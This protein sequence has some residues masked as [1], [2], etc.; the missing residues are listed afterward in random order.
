MYAVDLVYLAQ[1]LVARK[2][3]TLLEAINGKALFLEK[4]LGVDITESENFV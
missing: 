1:P 4:P 2:A 3:F